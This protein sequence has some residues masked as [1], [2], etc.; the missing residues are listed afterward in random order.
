MGAADKYKSNIAREFV[1]GSLPDGVRP[2]EFNTRTA[3]TTRIRQTGQ[4]SRRPCA[5]SLEPSAF[6]HP[7]ADGWP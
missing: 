3:R 6:S 1:Q 7:P 2:E 5:R 4:Y